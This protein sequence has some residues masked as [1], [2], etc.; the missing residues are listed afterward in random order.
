MSVEV[1]FFDWGELIEEKTIKNFSETQ[2]PSLVRE[3]R[4]SQVSKMFSAIISK[5]HK[6]Q[7]DICHVG[8]DEY[9]ILFDR[10][11]KSSTF[12]KRILAVQSPRY[13]AKGDPEAQKLI[14]DY[15]SMSRLDFENQ[16]S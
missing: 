1:A 14:K 9:L 15:L 2:V 3:L 10:L 8:K 13:T 5:S 11:T 12:W 4:E 6:D 7:I 16:Y